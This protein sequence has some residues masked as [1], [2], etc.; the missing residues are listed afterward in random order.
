MAQDLDLD[1]G[2][3]AAAI[4]AP[5]AWSESMAQ[6][7]VEAGLSVE[8]PEGPSVTLAIG[9]LARRLADWSGDAAL[10]EPLETLLLDAKVAFDPPLVRAALAPGAEIPLSAVLLHWASDSELDMLSRV[11]RLLAAG[12]RIGLSG[13]PSAAALDALEAAARLA[14]PLARNGVALMLRPDAQNAPALIADEA[15]RGRAGAALAAGARALDAALAELAIEAVR[16]GLDATRGGVQRKAAAAR[17]AGAPDADILA[18]LSGAVARGAYSA[19]LDAGA[20]P[21]RRRVAV[22][23]PEAGAHA[24]TVYGEGASD[25]TGALRAADERGAVGASLA[26]TRFFDPQKGFDAAGF[27]DAVRLLTRALDATHG[28][29][30]ASPRRPIILRLEGLASLI[31]RAGLAFDSK[32]ARAAGASVSALA[33]GAALGESFS[34]AE[35]KAS[36]PDWSRARRS[37]E[38]AAKLARDAAVALVETDGPFQEAALRAAHL[39]RAFVGAKTRG[40]RVCVTIAFA[41]DAASARRA[42]ASAMG[43]APLESIAG[44]ALRDGVFGRVL[45]DDARIGLGA[46][47][48]DKAQISLLAAHVEG[49][50]TLK[51]APGVNLEN[52]RAKGLTDTALEAIEEAARDAFNIRAAVHPLVIGPELCEE[53]LGLPADVAAG[54]RGDLLMTLGFSEDDIAAAEAFCMGAGALA[55]A[56]GLEEAHRAIFNTA[57]DIAPDAQLAL[58]AAIAPFA[59]VAVEL[60]LRDADPERRAALQAQASAAGLTLLK[61]RSEAPPI[62]LTLPTLEED[63]DE[64]AR[65][66]LPAPLPANANVGG[67]APGV[68]ARRRLPDRRKGYIQKA[69]VGGHKVYLHTGEYDDGAL[70]EIFIDLHKEGAA[71]RSLMNNFAISLSIGLQYGVP[72]EEYCDAFLFTRFEPAGEVKGNAAIRHATSILDYIFRELSVSYLGRADLAHVDPFDARGDG[73][74]RGANE[75][76]SA[77]R[78]ISRGFSRG[79]A[80]DNLVMLRPRAEPKTEPRREAVRSTRTSPRYRAEPCVGCGHFTVDADTGQCAA[81]GAKGEAKG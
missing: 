49:R 23:S 53:E 60:T 45:S 31:M 43:V 20:D 21:T 35:T 54:K 56:P 36:Y 47:G 61:L 66:A 26:L 34:M 33:L 65:H 6:A 14:D 8:T 30:G 1:D 2:A 37:E 29:E 18:A 62:T 58:A 12:A 64:P 32:A 11:Q 75:A 4:D 16:S 40:Q 74:S 68:H 3:A 38:A 39:L 17:L 81:C 73:L 78:L 63:A 15:A 24:L 41:L 51:N 52:L 22:A 42:D 27:E 57:R 9:R 71:F 19:A 13:A 80:P 69:T 50:R 67:E 46:L 55:S 76:E 25:P 59:N 77:A 72:L 10:A 70:G 79:A 48:Y 7:A 5:P 28:G 44:F